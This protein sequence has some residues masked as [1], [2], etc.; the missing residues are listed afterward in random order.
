MN[1]EPDG[2]SEGEAKGAERNEAEGGDGTDESEGTMRRTDESLG[3]IRGIVTAVIIIALVPC[4]DLVVTLQAAT[5][6]PAQST[7]QASGSPNPDD[8]RRVV[9]NL[10]VGRYVDVQ[11]SSGLT[12]RGYIRKIAD[13]HFAVLLDGFAAPADIAYDDVRQLR[14]IPQ[15]VLRS[16]QPLPLKIEKVVSVVLV[17]GFFVMAFVQCHNKSC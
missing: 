4:G 6:Q 3:K 12:V 5:P 1:P 7:Y 13:D 2:Q 14:P 16:R 9:M 11:L 10:G 15:P 17:T 8:V